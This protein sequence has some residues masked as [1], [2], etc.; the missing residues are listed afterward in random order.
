MISYELAS[1]TEMQDWK[2]EPEHII[3][4]KHS[5][6]EE[7]SA[8][9]CGSCYGCTNTQ[10]KDCTLKKI[11]PHLVF[12]P[13]NLCDLLQKAGYPA[14][15]AADL[16]YSSDKTSGAY[17][18][19]ELTAKDL[20]KANSKL[21]KECTTLDVVKKDVFHTLSLLLKTRHEIETVAFRKFP[22]EDPL[23]VQQQLD[24]FFIRKQEGRK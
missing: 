15:V 17:A 16:A 11:A 12:A 23:I 5:K 14:D 8:I 20:Q 18:Y 6:L 24:L 13:R 3:K 7:W 4:T 2:W 21:Y 1:F 10:C 9:Q 19:Q 22:N